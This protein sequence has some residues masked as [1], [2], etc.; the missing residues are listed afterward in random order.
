MAN[1]T[2]YSN[3]QTVA[4]YLDSALAPAFRSKTVMMALMH[5]VNFENGSDSKKLRK[6]GTLTAT[7]A[8]ESQDHAVSEYTQTTPNTLTAAQVKVYVEL[9][10]KATLFG[11]ADI[12]QLVQEGGA[13]LAQKFDT[14]ALA[15]LDALNGGTQVGT[16][17]AALTASI[18]LQANYTLNA[19]NVTDNLVYVLHP[20]QIYDIQGEILTSTASVWSNP[21]EITLFNAAPQL[22]GLRG[23]FLG[24]PVFQTTNT[25][26]VN[27]DADWAG[28]HFAAGLAL[29]AGIGPQLRSFV[30]RNIKKGVTELSIESWYDVKEY[31]DTAGV[32]IE[33]DK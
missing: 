7:A 33:T 19:A 12:E 31:N 18:L 5:L 28:G 11:G 21:T 30:G 17:G 29:A 26:S 3:Y 2:E 10:D 13:A 32:S 22:N 4:A 27:G 20:R 25:E 16:S 9:S 14:D 23:F 15:L 1:E 6:A 24:V 8:T